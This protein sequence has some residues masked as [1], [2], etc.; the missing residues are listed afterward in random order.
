MCKLASS[1]YL[2]VFW[3][4][5]FSEAGS[6]AL[7]NK[8]TLRIH[9]RCYW[10]YYIYIINMIIIITIIIIYYTTVWLVDYSGIYCIMLT[11]R[12][13]RYSDP[14]AGRSKWEFSTKVS[15]TCCWSIKSP[16]RGHCTPGSVCLWLI[17]HRMTCSDICL[18][19]HRESKYD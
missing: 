8:A 11:L 18:I 12:H 6:V 2:S 5:S 15:I 4:W 7:R 1:L 13:T 17:D 10:W 9:S 16:P 19:L 14:G 3:L